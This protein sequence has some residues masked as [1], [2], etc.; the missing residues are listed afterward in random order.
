MQDLLNDLTW[1]DLAIITK[2]GE[3]AV[4][5]RETIEGK[6]QSKYKFRTFEFER[7]EWDSDD[8]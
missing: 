1:F 4:T 5:I 6:L 3:F 2:D 7:E 8:N